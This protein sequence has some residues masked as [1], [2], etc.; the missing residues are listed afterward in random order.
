MLD[1]RISIAIALHKRNEQFHLMT[2]AVVISDELLERNI[3]NDF[4][5][6]YAHKQDLSAPLTSL[7][8][9]LSETTDR[10]TIIFIASSRLKSE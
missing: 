4:G 8:F 7:H 3:K 2:H 10:K 6:F 1:L 9:N 5:P